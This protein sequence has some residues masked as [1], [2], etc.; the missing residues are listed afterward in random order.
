MATNNPTYDLKVTKADVLTLRRA[1]ALAHERTRKQ[2]K[3]AQRNAAS[4]VAGWAMEG[5]DYKELFDKL[6]AFVK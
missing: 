5:A 3:R 1:L 2:M 4:T 6:G